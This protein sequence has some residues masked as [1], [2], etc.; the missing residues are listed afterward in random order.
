MCT[1]V[2]RGARDAPEAE[3]RLA[4]ALSVFFRLGPHRP[5]SAIVNFRYGS[6][7]PLRARRKLTLT[8]HPPEDR[9][10]PPER[11][12]TNGRFQSAAGVRRGQLPT[13]GFNRSCR[14]SVEADRLQLVSS[15]G[16]SS[17]VYRLRRRRE[18]RLQPDVRG[19]VD[20]GTGRGAE[21]PRDQ[22]RRAMRAYLATVREGRPNASFSVIEQPMLPSFRKEIAAGTWRRS[23]QC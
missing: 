10:V 12:P 20:N 13:A 17:T 7:V 21:D 5:L 2:G 9:P 4:G 1:G 18:V 6:E 19:A 23:T 15:R 8:G 3:S 14:S 16:S 22:V 11:T